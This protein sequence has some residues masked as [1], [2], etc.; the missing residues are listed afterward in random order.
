VS[1]AIALEVVAAVD[2]AD[3]ES[4]QLDPPAHPVNQEVP[5]KMVDPVNPVAQDKM[6]L[7]LPLNNNAKLAKSAHPPKTEEPDPPAHPDQT[8]IPAA[9]DKMP[10]AA[11][12]AHPD[13]PAH[14]DQEATQEAQD[15]QVAQDSQDNLPKAQALKDQLDLPAHLA[16]MVNQAAQANPAQMDSPVNPAPVETMELQVAQDNPVEMEMQEKLVAK[17]AKE[18][19]TTAHPHALPQD[20]KPI[21]SRLVT[22]LDKPFS[23][24]KLHI[25][26]Q[27]NLHKMIFLFFL[28]RI[29]CPKLKL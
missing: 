21:D 28:S 22:Q 19:A 29:H 24:S 23:L 14:P 18:L 8:E 17:E 16:K 4:P 25:H 15:S 12:E 3:A 20:I 11:D 5:D 27:T 6:L 1:R 13:H 26:F 2:A 9:Q 10:M 7:Q